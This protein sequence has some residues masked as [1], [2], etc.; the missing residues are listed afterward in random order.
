MSAAYDDRRHAPRGGEDVAGIVVLGGCA[1]IAGVW[2]IGVSRLHLRN[3]QC[4]EL[5]LDFAV[6]L[7][8]AGLIISDF[9]GRRQRREESWPHP[10]LHVPGE[11]DEKNLLR[12]REEGSTLLGYNAHEEPWFWPDS[13]RLKHGVIAGGTGSGK[14]T[15]LKSIIAQ[16]LNRTF[17]GN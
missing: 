7:F 12:A 8:G 2:Y 11:V 1:L 5:F 6:I 17:H 3:A 4:L 15:F 16:D 14:T 9:V 10:A 13:V